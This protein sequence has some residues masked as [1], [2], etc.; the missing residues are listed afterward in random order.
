VFAFRHSLPQLTLLWVRTIKEAMMKTARMAKPRSLPQRDARFW[1]ACRLSE[2]AFRSAAQPLDLLLFTGKTMLNK[3]QRLVT[4]SRYDHV[5][6][7]LRDSKGRLQ[8]LEATGRE[9]P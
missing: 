2:V 1:K 7:L 9:V 5:A 4:G 6:L 8:L 3:M